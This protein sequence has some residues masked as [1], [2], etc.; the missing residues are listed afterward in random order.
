MKSYFTEIW[1]GFISFQRTCLGRK[2]EEE[3]ILVVKGAAKD[4]HS[5]TT[6]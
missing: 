1:L 3:D 4:G 6:V 2:K 5:L